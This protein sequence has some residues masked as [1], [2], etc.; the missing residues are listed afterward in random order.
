MDSKKYCTFQ[1]HEKVPANIFCIFCKIYMCAKCESFHSKLLQNHKVFNIENLNN[2]DISQNFCQQEKHNIELQYYCKNHNQLCCAK[3]ITKIK[4]KENGIHKDC[5]VCTIE[6]IRDEKMK[7]LNK[8]INNLEILSKNL[9]ESINKLKNIFEKINENKEDIKTKIQKIFTKIR[10]ELNNREDLLLNEVDDI[11]NKNFFGEEI[12]KQGEKLPN[13]VKKS[14]EKCKLISNND[15]ENKIIN[16]INDCKS[17][18]D[19]I[20][21][22]NKI[23]DNINKYNNLVDVKILFYPME[24][25]NSQTIKINK[26]YKQFW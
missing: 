20:N 8:N 14:L 23:N 22:I 2:D 12:I 26:R 16:L 24:E 7:N 19:N 25:E 18:E 13:K 1:G 17:I 6:E 15:E 10:N 11:F 4:N 3:C 5:D 21:D 9:Y